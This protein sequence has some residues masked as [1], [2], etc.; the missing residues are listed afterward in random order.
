MANIFIQRGTS[1]IGNSGGTVTLSTPVS[2]LNNAFFLNTNNRHTNGGSSLTAANLEADDLS[3]GGYLSATDT[4][5]FDR[6]AGSTASGVFSWEVWE[7][8]GLSGGP[9]E[10][11]VRGRYQLNLGTSENI[12]QTL[13][14]ISNPDK[15]IPFING[16]FSSSTADDADNLTAIAWLSGST[17]N[18]KRGGGTTNNVKVYV[19]VVEFTGSNWTVKH[20]RSISAADTG[21]IT[22]TDNSDGTTPG[23]GDVGDWSNAAIFHQQVA[24]STANVDDA[25][26][27]TSAIFYPGTNTST[28]N[29]AFHPNHVDSGSGASQ[30]VHVLQHPHLVV[31]RYTDTQS[32]QGNMPVNISSS[33]LESLDTSSVIVSRYSSGAGTAYGRGWVNVELTDINTATLWAHRSGNTIE[34]RIQILDLR[35]PPTLKITDPIDKA[36]I[37]GDSGVVFNGYGFGTIQGTGKLELA[38]S[39]DYSTATKIAQSIVNWSD[40]S[41]TFNATLSSLG[42]G[43]N[44]AFV[45]KDNGDRSSAYRIINTELAYLDT[46]KSLGPDIYHTFN[47][48]YADEQGVAAANSQGT[49]GSVGF[50]ATPITRGNTY[51]WTVHNNASRIVMNDTVYT[52]ITIDHT[53]RY[54]GGWIQLDRVHLVPSGIYEE[55]GGINNIYMV[56]GFGNKILFNIADSGQGFKIQAFSDIK[57]SINRPYFLMLKFE[58]AGGENRFTAFVDGIEVTKTDGN[59]VGYNTLSDHSGNWSYGK[60]DGILDTG[61]T[62]IVYPGAPE[63]LFSHWVTFSEYGGGAPLSDEEIRVK[64]F[65]L[66]AIPTDIISSDTETNMQS[67]IDSLASTTYSDKVLPI[68]IYT[69]SD[70][71]NITLS[72]DNI[73]FD[74]KCSMHIQWMGSPSRTLTIVNNGSSNCDISKVSTP[75]GGTVIVQNPATLTITGLVVGSEVRIY[76][77]DGTDTYFGTELSGV[78]NNPSTSYT[79]TYNTGA[80]DIIVQVMKLGYVEI[81]LPFSLDGTDQTLQINQKM[82]TN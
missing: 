71:E 50:V 75:Y 33:A 17:L 22:L 72:L 63:T 55:G 59:P 78:E 27:D 4:I 10:F 11:I 7:Y 15:C 65:E 13:S 28:V 31:T 12:T 49:V 35:T 62:D 52:N 80:N 2:S 61:G 37:D 19:T 47:N 21:T 40:T 6:Q 39:V 76:D 53:K 64:L 81:N 74:D 58:G 69:A 46:V 57:L 48:T 1:D 20:G 25:I 18:V 68:Q 54:V 79:Y 23:D 43:Y 44:W 82:D 42:S 73:V 9:D 67:A 5:Q 29:W 51:S 60:P 3:G 14:G 16:I 24:N 66:G 70:K 41:I 36:I 45:T 26:S 30:F 56:V 38:D 34:S 8:T 32:A 77:N